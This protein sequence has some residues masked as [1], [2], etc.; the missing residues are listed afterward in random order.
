[1][2]GND[3]GGDARNLGD[4]GRSD[5]ACV[6][7]ACGDCWEIAGL[8]GADQGTGL[9]KLCFRYEHV[10]VRD[11]DALLKCIQLRIIE[12]F[13]PRTSDSVILGLGRLPALHLFVGVRH[14]NFR[15]QIVWAHGTPCQKARE[16]NCYTYPVYHQHH[17][18]SS[19]TIEV[20]RRIIFH[21]SDRA[22]T[23]AFKP[24]SQT[25][26]VEVH[27]GCRE[28]GKHLADE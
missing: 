2:I 9:A 8:S 7:S 4:I 25:I 13:P 17:L 5:G 6:G 20:C 21:L 16:N 14:D 26:E 28:K 24:P 23:P 27:H 19:Q 12:D 11:A 3:L 10:L 22:A 15:P 18:T 1:M